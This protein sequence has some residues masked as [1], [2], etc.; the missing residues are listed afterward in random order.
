MLATWLEPADLGKH[1]LRFSRWSR[2]TWSAPVTIVEDAR[3]VANWADVP[4]VAEGGDGSLVAHWAQASGSGAYAYDAVVA[5]STDGGATW[6]PIGPLHDD[7]TASEHGFVS[8]VG[9][10]RGVRAFWL[11]GRATATEGGAMTLRT[12]VVG[13]KVGDGEVVDTMVCDCCGTSAGSTPAGPIV[14][15]R[16]RTADEMRDI[17]VARR[18]ADAWALPTPVHRDGWQ[19]A[20][21]PVNGPAISVQDRRVAIAWYTY[22]DSTHRVR[23]A[24]SEDAG[25]TFGAAIEV[26][27][28]RGSRAPLGRVSIALADDGTAIVGWLASDREDAVVLLRCVGRDGG[29]GAELRIGGNLAGRDAGFPR[30]ARSG[31]DVIAIW[32]ESAPASRLR[33]VAVPLAAIPFLGSPSDAAGNVQPALL[34][35]GSASPALE[36]IALDKT[37]VSLAVLRGKVVLLNLWATWCEPCRHEL[38]LL[39]KLH[40]RAASRG[41]A[42]VAVNIDR[43]RPRDEIADYVARRKLP[44]TVWLDPDD[45]VSASLGATTYPFNVLIGRDGKVVWWRA[46][47]IRAEDPELQAALESVLE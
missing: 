10:P 7:R 9:D 32:T 34:A 28:P 27:A 45:R 41:L 25:A 17:A 16:D 2:G 33:A 29:L 13:A 11:D 21:C 1:R 47:A 39:A 19:I 24:F 40:D 14:A 38:P 23:V 36:A 4:S 20:G 43:N 31:D 35:L 30:L 42:I 12:A 3:I 5:R 44:F 18:G 22:A 46:G 15:Y 26:D 6:V 37:P 8:L